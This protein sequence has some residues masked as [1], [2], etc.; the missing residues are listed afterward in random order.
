MLTTVWSVQK[1]PLAGLGL[2]SI[3]R[4][5]FSSL[6][7][8]AFVYL[9]S[10]VFFDSDPFCVLHCFLFDFESQMSVLPVHT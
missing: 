3:M 6:Y 5:L 4:V 2:D 7:F 8:S 1:R 9:C 10:F